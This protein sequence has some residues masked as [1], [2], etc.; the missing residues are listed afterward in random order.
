MLLAMTAFVAIKLYHSDDEMKFEGSV[1]FNKAGEQVLAYF[2][3]EKDS[4]KHVAAKFILE[5]AA[6]HFHPLT[7]FV[8][9]TNGFVDFNV[10][11]YK[12][13]E[14]IDKAIDSLIN[15]KKYRLYRVSAWDV[16]S[17]SAREI[18]DNIEMAFSVWESKPWAKNATFS[19][20]CEY[21]LPYRAYDEPLENWRN[22][23]FDHYDWIGDSISNA[24]DPVEAC[25]LIN[26]SLSKWLKFDWERGSRELNSQS[27]SEVTQNKYG[28]CRD[29]VMMA[30]CAMRAQGIPVAIDYVP[31]WGHRNAGH[32][33]NVVLSNNGS[34][35]SFN[36]AEKNPGEYQ[37]IEPHF[38]PG[39]IFRHSYSKQPEA[40][41]SIK[42]PEDVVPDFLN[43]FNIKDVTKEY[44][45]VGEVVLSE[46]KT[47]SDTRFVYLCVYNGGNWKPV[48]WSAIEN[49]KATFEDMDNNNVLY[50]P[51]YFL[52]NQ[53]L[54]AGPPFVFS[55]DDSIKVL[56]GSE[57]KAGLTVK[58]L[59]SDENGVLKGVF[60][61]NVNYVL[62]IWDG[63]WKRIDQHT[64]DSSRTVRFVD[65]P[66][67]ALLRLESTVL[68][69]LY[70]RP[71][72][73]ENGETVFL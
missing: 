73:I 45:S 14:E 17:L 66:D 13:S 31:Y 29:L 65:V 38:K 5:N 1:E 18:I 69:N 63:Y 58:H 19:Q 49:G 4:L 53:L 23:L 41:A 44:I 47:P 15:L 62:S 10:Y 48:Y 46:L 8:D 33:W 51:M 20:F 25:K 34:M 26:T 7:T 42:E 35:V 67:N 70:Q 52:K 28:K 32:F 55:K 43:K 59:Y 3:E 9:S 64:A 12:T 2:N 39:K 36:S 11:A 6:Y 61:E 54:P 68:D 24:G 40:L 57:K 30:T 21:I 50:L 72:I 37:A 71:M 60:E 22:G 56:E 16:D 27:I